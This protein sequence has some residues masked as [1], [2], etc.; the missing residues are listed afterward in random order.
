MIDHVITL[1]LQV[2]NLRP[3]EVVHV[4]GASY[5]TDEPG[6]EL[7]SS[8]SRPSTVWLPQPAPPEQTWSEG[9]YHPQKF[10]EEQSN[11]S[12]HLNILISQIINTIICEP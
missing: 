10:W 3:R 4:H 2:R 12:R 11:E 6:L 7:G 8:S 9:F 5:L 1:T